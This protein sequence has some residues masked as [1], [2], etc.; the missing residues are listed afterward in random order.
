[1]IL[2]ER[3][4]FVRALERQLVCL[5]YFKDGD[6]SMDDFAEAGTTLTDLVENYSL[7]M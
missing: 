4:W 2:I 7:S 3:L 5:Q 6:L 1:V